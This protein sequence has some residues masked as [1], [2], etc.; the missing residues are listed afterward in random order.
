MWV[1]FVDLNQIKMTCSLKV[2]TCSWVLQPSPPLLQLVFLHQRVSV[3]RGLQFLEGRLRYRLRRHCEI[4]LRRH[5]L[6]SVVVLPVQFPR[7]QVLY[8]LL[9][10]VRVV[11]LMRVVEEVH[12]SEAVDGDDRKIRRRLGQVRQR[13]REQF[14][15]SVQETDTV[16]TTNKA[17]KTLLLCSFVLKETSF[18]FPF[19]GFMQQ[20]QWKGKQ[21]KIWFRAGLFRPLC[22]FTFQGL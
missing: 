14:S 15:V 17:V 6:C 13:M 18:N 22:I 3:L 5:H 10:S 1:N 7:V 16:Y 21:H 9:Q 2:S 11:E 19:L 8:E 20:S 4:V 12:V